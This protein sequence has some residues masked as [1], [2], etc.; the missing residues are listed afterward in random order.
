MNLEHILCDSA[1]QYGHN[2]WLCRLQCLRAQLPKPVVELLLREP[3]LP[4]KLP[5]CQ[6]AVAALLDYLKPVLRPILI[7]Y[8]QY[9]SHASPSWCEV[10]KNVLSVF[11]FWILSHS[12]GRYERRGIVERLLLEHFCCPDIP[13][14]VFFF[15]QRSVLHRVSGH[16][17][18]LDRLIESISQ[19]LVNLSDSMRSQIF[20]TGFYILRRNRFDRKQIS[21]ILVHDSRRDILQLHITDE[22][23]NIVCNQALSAFIGR[24]RPGVHTID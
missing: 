1:R 5:V 17:F 14:L 23:T 4:A 19:C 3:P 13:G 24:H 8:C 6:T 20:C 18:P 12:F 21:V 2:L 9:L 16:Q 15:R 7:S 10:S 11:E 22:G